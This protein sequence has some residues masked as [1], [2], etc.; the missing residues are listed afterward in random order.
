MASDAASAHDEPG[1]GFWTKRRELGPRGRLAAYVVGT[2][3]ILVLAVALVLM[4]LGPRRERDVMATRLRLKDAVFAQAWSPPPAELGGRE[5]IVWSMLEFSGMENL[6]GNGHPPGELLFSP[7]RADDA[8]ATWVPYRRLIAS[9]L[10]AWEC[11]A[12]TSFESVRAEGEPA[13]VALRGPAWEEPVVADRSFEGLLSVGYR[14][15]ATRALPWDGTP[16]GLREL[17][18]AGLAME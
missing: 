15:G 1:P 16:E 11:D 17:G 14:S 4:A 2:A 7:P 12:L 8:P 18:I 13:A 6:D 9:P 10:D 5:R 3:S